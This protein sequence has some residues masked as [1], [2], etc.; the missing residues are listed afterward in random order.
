MNRFIASTIVTMGIGL[1]ANVWAS[2]AGTQVS[3]STINLSAIGVGDIGIHT[4]LRASEC[5]SD[6]F[7]VKVINDGL[8]NDNHVFFY[9]DLSIGLDSLGHY[10]INIK[11]SAWAGITADLALGE[12]LFQIYGA[13]DG[14]DEDELQAEDTALIVDN[15]GVRR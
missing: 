7:S 2:Q 10:V 5:E 14:S 11:A 12:A 15:A 8:P 9:D 1:S 6:S 4:Q 13:C 3:P